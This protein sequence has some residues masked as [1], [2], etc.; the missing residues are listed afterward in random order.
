LQLLESFLE[1]LENGKAFCEYFDFP[2]LVTPVLRVESLRF[3]F[4]IQEAECKLSTRPEGFGCR[5]WGCG[6]RV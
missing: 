3:R 1:G 6:L 5:V 4:F 2:I